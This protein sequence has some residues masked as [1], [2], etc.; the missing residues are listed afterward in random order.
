MKKESGEAKIQKT[1]T[2]LKVNQLRRPGQRA[3]E[4]ATA[5]RSTLLDGRLTQAVAATDTGHNDKFTLWTQHTV[6]GG[7]GAKVRW[8]EIYPS[9]PK[10]IQNGSV[11]SNSKYDF[12]GAISPNRAVQGIEQVGRQEHG[13]ELRRLVE[14]QLPDHQDG[15]EEGRQQ[16]V[17]PGRR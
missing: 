17:R 13:A 10:L 5:R 6:S 15:L 11:S 1:A 12:D 9:D 14:L 8:Y 4:W 3:A 2:Q 7:A 16:P